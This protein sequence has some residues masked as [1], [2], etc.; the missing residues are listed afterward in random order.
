MYSGLN[1]GDGAV[2][3]HVQRGRFGEVELEEAV[4]MSSADEVVL[5][6]VPMEDEEGNVE[7]HVIAVGAHL[8]SSTGRVIWSESDLQQAYHRSVCMGQMTSMLKDNDRNRVYAQAIERLIKA[9]LKR[10]SRPPVVLD[11]GTGTGLLALLAARAGAKVVYAIEMFDQMAEIAH[12]IIDDN[13]YGDK[14]LVI[15]GKSTEI[16]HLPEPCDMLIS[17]LLDSALLG[18]SVIPTHVDAMERFLRPGHENFVIPNRASIYVSLVE[19]EEL[20]RMFIVEDHILGGATPFRSDEARACRGGRVLVPVDWTNFSTRGAKMLSEAKE[21]LVVDMC[22]GKVNLNGS[23]GSSAVKLEALGK[24]KVHGLLVYWNVHLLSAEFDPDKTLSYST[25]PGEQNWQD[26][27]LQV[28]YPLPQAIDCEAGDMIEVIAGRVHMS[29]WFSARQLIDDTDKDVK[30]MKVDD[31]LHIDEVYGE[32]CSCGWHLLCGAERILM[33]NDF[34]RVQS[35]DAAISHI[36]GALN[37]SDEIKFIVDVADGSVLSFLLHAKLTNHSNIKIITIENAQFSSIF[38]NQLIEANGYGNS[39]AVVENESELAEMNEYFFEKDSKAPNFE[40]SVLMSECFYYQLHALPIWR[41]LSFLYQRHSLREHLSKDVLVVP[42][43]A[44]VMAAAFELSSLAAGHGDVG[45]VEE[46]DHSHFDQFK[47]DWTQYSFPYKL[48]CYD[49]KILTDPIPV[50]TI[51]FNKNDPEDIYDHTVIA[52]FLKPGTCHCIATWVDYELVPDVQLECWDGSNF[53]PYLK[54][55]VWF[56][57]KPALIEPTSHALQ[58]RS[59]FIF[60]DSD[61]NFSY[62]VN[63]I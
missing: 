18:E 34:N 37:V 58:L 30:K 39:M 44:R 5:C 8:D 49:K 1:K 29:L 19:S 13:G 12:Q 10:E 33:L 52:P 24:G 62:E 63:S 27:W 41:C 3:G 6:A 9:F 54:A 38:A 16:D 60:G 21:V 28:L 40:I 42:S 20:Q 43:K 61:I 47:G 22:G 48:G 23:N 7:H 11:I 36:V 50:M 35:W 45:M 14:I 53:P 56:L 25:G 57:S 55:S 15:H 17:E 4:A 2:V 31:D 51:S 46:F 26:H 59:S 32:Q